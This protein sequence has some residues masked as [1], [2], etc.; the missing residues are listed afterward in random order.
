MN[1]VKAKNAKASSTGQIQLAATRDLGN[2]RERPPVAWTVLN[3]LRYRR[4]EFPK[5]TAGRFLGAIS[6]LITVEAMLRGRVYRPDFSRLAPEQ[7][8]KLKELLAL[9]VPVHELARVFGGNVLEYGVMSRRLITTAGVNYLVDAFQNIVEI[10]NMKFHGFGTG[11]NAEATGDTTLQTEETTQYNPDNTRPTGS[12]TEGASAN[13]YRTVGTYSPDSGGTRA[14]TE[15][16]IFSANTGGT[17]WDRSVF[18]AV[19]LVA[20]S[21]SLQVTHDTT[22][23]AGG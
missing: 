6:G 10:D 8:Q 22:C 18:S 9:N 12:Q 16:G 4:R 21:D 17:L 7:I 19:N 3:W 23:S 2:L 15:H 13:I 5:H 11:T 1:I 20:G 14:I